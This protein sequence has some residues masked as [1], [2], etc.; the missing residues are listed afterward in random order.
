MI[1]LFVMMVGAVFAADSVTPPFNTFQNGQVTEHIE[2]RTDHPVYMSSLRQAQNMSPLVEGPIT[3]RPGSE[4]AG[5]WEEGSI[6]EGAYPLLFTLDASEMPTKPGPPSMTPTVTPIPV[7][8]VA[9]IKAMTGSNH[10]ELVNSIDMGK[11]EMVPP[12]AS[13]TGVFDGNSDLGYK[14]S[15]M[16][17]QTRSNDY[18][19]FQTLGPGAEVYNLTLEN[20][21]I[22]GTTA[23]D[24]IGL[25]AG[26]IIGPNVKISNVDFIGTSWAVPPNGERLY[27]RGN[28]SDNVGALCGKLDINSGGIEI[29]GC[30]IV[31]LGFDTYDD[32]GYNTGK[33]WG[34]LIGNMGTA[35]AGASNVY[36]TDCTVNGLKMSAERFLG[37]FIASCEGANMSEPVEIYNVDA[38]DIQIDARLNSN[39][40]VGGLIGYSH[41]VA[42]TDCN[43]LNSSIFNG[44]ND[45]IQSCTHKGGLVGE[46]WMGGSSFI[47]C[48]V[49]VDITHDDSSDSSFS[50]STHGGFFGYCQ[51]DA[52]HQGGA[53]VV[54]GCSSAGDVQHITKWYTS[55]AS[56]LFGGFAGSVYEQNAAA[57]LGSITFDRCWSTGNVSTNNGD[58]CD[59]F[60]GFLG[61]LRHRE[62]SPNDLTVNFT[63]C[64]SWGKVTTD[65]TYHTGWS[66]TGIGVG[67]FIGSFRKDAVSTGFTLNLENCYSA[68]TVDR[69]GSTAITNG[70]TDG[71]P[72]VAG[73]TGY[74][75]LSGGLTKNVTGCFWDTTTSGQS[76]T[77]AMEGVVGKTTAEMQVQQTYSTYD[78]STVDGVRGTIADIWYA[79]STAQ[80][81]GQPDG[82]R[83]IPFVF[84]TDDSYILSLLP[85]SIEFFRTD[86]GISGRIQE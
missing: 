41:N 67:G 43:V 29:T 32:W 80:L 15:F 3:K 22:I 52:S 64:Y 61:M 35:S 70:I 78:F 8:T 26:R 33:Y 6:P 84:N 40:G 36:I 55:T 16:K 57:S 63:D 76:G 66:P 24:N 49:E 11:V 13:F 4:L 54:R 65:E 60:G 19:M 69:D 1:I 46:V 21:G 85:D 42:V 53:F 51:H 9:D 7:S 30:D 58:K 74:V 5:Y 62:P 34:G 79:P 72:N 68:Q 45:L 14:I 83:L 20:C 56:F 44:R 31:K 47:D 39:R 18:G 28:G 71:T 82:A 50:A 2:G 73:F 75:D 86:N 81:G 25:L 17:L 77:D 12:T 48:H 59:R 38:N 10:Y 23:Y 37:G 27:L